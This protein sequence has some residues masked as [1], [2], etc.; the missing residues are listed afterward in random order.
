LS[1]IQVTSLTF[2]PIE[3]GYGLKRYRRGW[4]KLSDNIEI[5]KR[6]EI[7]SKQYGTKFDIKDGTAK[8]ML[9]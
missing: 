3:L 1:R 9:N 4:P 2:Y 6:L 8:V 5:L 7:L